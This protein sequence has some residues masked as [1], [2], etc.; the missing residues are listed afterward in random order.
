MGVWQPD[1]LIVETL[2]IDAVAS[3]PVLAVNIAAVDQL[4]W[5]D[6][7]EDVA[8]VVA[9]PI[10]LTGTQCPKILTCLWHNLAEYLKDDPAL[11]LV[12]FFIIGIPDANIEIALGVFSIEFRQCLESLFALRLFLIFVNPS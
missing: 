7:M 6:A 5:F 12:F 8:L 4:A 1:T 10:F 2:A 9:A 3:R 11:M